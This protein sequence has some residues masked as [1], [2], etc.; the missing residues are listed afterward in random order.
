MAFY[1]VQEYAKIWNRRQIVALCVLLYGYHLINY[2]RKSV[3]YN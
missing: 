2:L 3:K 1:D